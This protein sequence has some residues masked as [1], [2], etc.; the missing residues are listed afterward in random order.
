MGAGN[1]VAVKGPFF[2]R[3]WVGPLSVLLLSL[4][5]ANIN[6]LIF[7]V[8]LKFETFLQGGGGGL[9]LHQTLVTE[10]AAAERR[11]HSFNNSRI[12]A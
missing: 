11:K 6:L 10:L 7:Q 4:A 5:P 1:V 12:C 9:E 3:D 2:W 8:P